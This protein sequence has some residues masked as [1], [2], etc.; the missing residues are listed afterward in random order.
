[1]LRVWDTPDHDELNSVHESESDPGLVRGVNVLMATL[2][3]VR[4]LPVQLV[5]RNCGAPVG[6]GFFGLRCWG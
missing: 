2:F 1:M 4:S 6:V 5:E 3:T